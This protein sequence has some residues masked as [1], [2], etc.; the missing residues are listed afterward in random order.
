MRRLLVN[1][2]KMPFLGWHDEAARDLRTLGAHLELGI[3][4][5]LLGPPE[6]TSLELLDGYP[7]ELLVFG[8]DLGHAHY[9]APDTA[10]PTWLRDLETTRRRRHRPRDH[11]HQRT[12]AAT[13]MS[14]IALLPGD[15][16][17]GEILDGPVNTCTAWP[18]TAPRSP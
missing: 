3:L 5:D 1:H 8:G 6:Q 12:K 13:P 16:I 18:P 2:P 11:D 14:T 7:H 9:P 15:G 4:P 10:V 17:G